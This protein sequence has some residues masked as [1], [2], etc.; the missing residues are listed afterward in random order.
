M[1]EKL[2]NYTKRRAL[3]AGGLAVAAFF[4][5]IFKGIEKAHHINQESNEFSQPNLSGHL[6]EQGI[7]PKGVTTYTI[8][9]TDVNPI[10]VANKLGAKDTMTVASE[11]GA[12]V[13]GANSMEPGE[14][15]VIPGDQLTT[16]LADV[17]K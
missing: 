10:Q 3:L 2:P 15:V 11:I 1:S 5:P 8:E 14:T 6:T 4:H 7:D 12:Q 17:K 9:P 13:G 16:T